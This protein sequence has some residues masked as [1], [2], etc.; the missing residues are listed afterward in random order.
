[1][2]RI[3]KTATLTIAAASS[4]SVYTGF[5]Q[6]RLVPSIPLPIVKLGTDEANG[7]FWIHENTVESPDEPLNKRGWTF[8]ESLLSPRIL[9]YGSKDLVW[10]CQTKPF[11]PVIAS[12]N[13]Y[14][15]DTKW[16]EISRLPSAVFNIPS[17]APTSIHDVWA[18]IESAYS[19]RELRY[20]KDR[21]L[22]L[23]GIIEEMQRVTGDT[24]IAGVWKSDIAS[25]LAWFR[26]ENVVENAA[27]YSSP[28]RLPYS[29]PNHPFW[30]WI[31]RFCPVRRMGVYE[32]ANKDKRVELL[33][34]S[35]KLADESAPFGHVEGAELEILGCMIQTTK[36]SD[37]IVAEK[38][39]TE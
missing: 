28:G 18:R 25:S 17:Q 12:H 33:S 15:T 37:E 31:T 1:M 39:K 38:S 26:G 4:N 35:V 6:D 10:K 23:G 14:S 34:W 36:I 11:E 5:L 22:A 29:P 27:P 7:K 19:K 3:Y 32:D 13:L 30:Y 2:G 8:Q 9:Y 20:P 16:S 24:Y 21:Y